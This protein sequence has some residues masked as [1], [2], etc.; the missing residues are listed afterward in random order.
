MTDMNPI[1]GATQQAATLCRT[2]QARGFNAS[3][4]DDDSPVTIADYGTQA[5]IC[6]AIQQHFP[7]EAVIG[8]EGGDAFKELVS[9][10]GQA[11]VASLIGSILGQDVSVPDVIGWLDY[12][13]DVTSARTW[14][15]DPIDG[16]VGFVN[17]RYYAI[18]VGV[19]HDLVPLEAV[20]GLPRSPID[21]DGTIIFTDGET[22][23]AMGMDGDNR[24]GVQA[25]Q[26]GATDEILIVDSIKLSEPEAA[27]AKRVRMAARI[28]GARMELYD[29]QLKYAMIAAG[30][31]DVFVRLPR[32]TQADPH[33]IWDHA[34]GA[35]LLR[36]AGG[37]ITD[38]MGMPLD[39]SQG[40]TLPHLGFVATNGNEELH[41]RIV[42][43]LQ[44][45][46]GA[47]WGF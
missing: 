11:Q 27:E 19:M 21:T 43:A 35:A 3:S 8:E 29:S 47:Q 22:V 6:R 16:T 31:G 13:R 17:G 9:A 24:R 1:I 2:I 23:T 44:E 40:T 25:S 34:S 30:Y 4:K 33:K 38:V 28:D 12:G 42:A 39:F 32:D 45:T 46:H 7:G 14:V 20:V 15:I 10:E 18:C 37:K 26:R 36:A 41:G 5:L